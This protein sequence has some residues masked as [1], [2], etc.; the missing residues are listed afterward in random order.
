MSNSQKIYVGCVEVKEGQFGELV[1]VALGPQ[2]FEKLEA[3]KN[4]RGWVNLN[5][6]KS[7]EGGYYMEVY[8]GA[9]GNGSGAKASNTQAAFTQNT[10]T[11]LPF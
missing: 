3:A 11:D 9:K 7:K 6:K 4:E 10:T 5:W 2:D 1:S 8:T